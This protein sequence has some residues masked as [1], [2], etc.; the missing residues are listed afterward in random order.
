[1]GWTMPSERAIFVDGRY[2]CLCRRS[3]RVGGCCFVVR[4]EPVEA[5][6]DMLRD[7]R[8]NVFIVPL[9]LARAPTIL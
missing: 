6:G 2:S 4:C 1:M 5:L 7:E 9:F 8:A 3:G